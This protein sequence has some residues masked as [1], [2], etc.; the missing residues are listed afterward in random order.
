MDLEHMLKRLSFCGSERR[1]EVAVSKVRYAHAAL[2]CRLD[3]Q[4]K[5]TMRSTA[6]SS[7]W[8]VFLMIIAADDAATMR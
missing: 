8:D 2:P 6:R 7:S 3:E 1:Q 4:M 5:E